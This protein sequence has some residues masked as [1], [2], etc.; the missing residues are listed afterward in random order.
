[1]KKKKIMVKALVDAIIWVQE[2]EQGNQKIIEF[3]D[4]LDFEE[5]EEKYVY[6][7]IEY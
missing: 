2:D 6:D 5:F 7:V 3:D 1:M 4:I